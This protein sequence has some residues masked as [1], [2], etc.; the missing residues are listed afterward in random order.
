MVELPGSGIKDRGSGIGDRGSGNDKWIPPDQSARD[1]I[2]AALDQ[3]LL[4]EAGAGSGKTTAMVERLVA[5]I[6][7]GA[8]TIDQVVAVT[9]TRKAAAELRERFQERLEAA[10]RQDQES[11]I[12]D[13]GTS[14]RGS[15]IEDRGTA[16]GAAAR[17]R[18]GHSADDFSARE[19]G[20]W[21]IGN[22]EWGMGIGDP[23]NGDPIK[24]SDSSFP[25]PYSPFPTGQQPNSQP[26]SADQRP[27]T[28]PS[29][30]HDDAVRRARSALDNLD[31][32]FLGTIHAFCARLLRERPLEAGVPPDFQE[33]YGAEE[34]LLRRESWHRFLERVA[35]RRRNNR[36]A[37]LLK[38]LRDVGLAPKQLFGLYSL[39]ADNGDVRFRADG[40]RAPTDFELLDVK[41]TLER[42]LTSALSLMPRNEPDNGWDDL[43]KRV[44][45]LRFSRDEM[46]WNDRVHLLN[47]ALEAV[48]GK[49]GVTLNRW[50]GDKRHY[51]LIKDLAAD[52]AALD[53]PTNPVRVTVMRWLAHRYTIVIRFARAAA[54]FYARERLRRGRLTFQDLLL[55]TAALLRDHQDVC[56]DFSDRY[57]YLLIDEFQDTD[58]VQ[59]EVLFRL[60]SPPS[61]DREW[62]KLE[63][64]AGALFV[65]GDPKQSIYRFRRADIALYLQ[66]KQRFREFGA[67][68]ELTANFRSAGAIGHFVNA[69]F[70]TRFPGTDDLSLHQATFAPLLT[71]PARDSEGVVAS[72]RFDQ[73]PGRGWIHIARPDSARLAPWIRDRIETGERQP[74]DFLVLT[75]TKHQLAQF[76]HALERNNVPYEISGAGIG[77]EEELSELILLLRA[78]ADPGNPVLTLAVLEGMFFG[79]DH[80]TLHEHATIGGHFHLLSRER[81]GTIVD[82]ALTQLQRMWE[83]AR[84]ETA[85]VAIPLIVD[86]LGILPYA[87]AGELG[88]TRAGALL[89][90]LDVLRQG[91][92]AGRTT[93]S[94][95][96]DL[97]ESA[98]DREDS[99]APLRPGATNVVRV[100]N[101]HRAKGLEARVVILA[102]P[103]E[104]SDRAPSIVQRRLPDGSAQGWFA[105]F[106]SSTRDRR[107]PIA[108]PMNWDVLE[109]EE[110]LYQDA[111]E[112]RLMYVAATRAADELI[113]ARCEKMEL[114]SVWKCFHELLDDSSLATELPLQPL[115]PQLREVLQ[116]DPASL[117][118]AIGRLRTDRE[119]LR[120]P[121]FRAGGVTAR[122]KPDDQPVRRG[123]RRSLRA[124]QLSLAIDAPRGAET[125]GYDREGKPIFQLGLPLDPG[126]QPAPNSISTSISNSNSN[127]E[128]E[129]QARGSEWGDAVH[130]TLHAAARGVSGEALKTTARNALLL[131]ECP[132]D[133]NGEPVWLGE[134][135]ALVDAMRASALWERAQSARRVLYEVPFELQLSAEEWQ[136]LSE[137]PSSGLPE[138]IIGRIDIV[139]QEAD[140]WVIADYKTDVAE[141]KAIRARIAQYRRQVDVYAFCWQ[142][143]TGQPVKERRLIMTAS[144]DNIV[145]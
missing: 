19:S 124:L 49:K 128:F 20:E 99:E 130:L 100:M 61:S 4:V 64:R 5:L 80:D 93:L 43:Q 119:L 140:G 46:K 10:V 111:E 34:E 50:T 58:P 48:Y 105:V 144:N 39:I 129:G 118:E 59:A 106:D 83:L 74:Q 79:I 70:S 143:L 52:W 57:R 96:I 81:T 71:N 126:A 112:N 131:A 12:K 1:R 133:E 44:R 95:A 107:K 67:V 14:D 38:C 97:L 91:S 90:A 103:L 29:N 51:D 115:P 145:W 16:D 110:R 26:A 28:L 109:V 9:F 113:V 6:L 31:S 120:R 21:G 56:R 101:L 132:A 127:L 41:Q 62:L 72:Y 13:Q 23:I 84:T 33:I 66:V 54:A 53:E 88:A 86:E 36:G 134:L 7:T 2:V 135:L 89:Y 24:A 47:A 125:F 32:C 76:A 98:L 75:R 18:S 139:F 60:A 122:I 77:L 137:Q 123:A 92:L 117:T 35:S 87:A 65:V 73:D 17:E 82:E 37:L 78:L 116:A 15:G 94:E 30:P 40:M 3:N 114:K 63:P 8:A 27:H 42:L 141:P 25:I 142:R 11:G 121:A 22:K 136:D 108:R 69:A 85:D 104:L 138:V 102:N 45:S 68:V 55:R